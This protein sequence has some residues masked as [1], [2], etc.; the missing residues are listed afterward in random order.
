MSSPS[1]NTIKNSNKSIVIRCPASYRPERKYVFDIL[2]CDRFSI[3]YYLEDS[4]SDSTIIALPSGK[5]I[6]FPDVFF[7]RDENEPFSCSDLPTTVQ[8]IETSDDWKEE[9]FPVFYG[10]E[11]YVDSSDVVLQWD[12]IAVLFFCLARWEELLEYPRDA[13]DRFVGTDS[14]LVKQAIHMYPIVDYCELYLR[15]IFTRLGLDTE[16]GRT[17][18]SIS[19]HDVDIHRYY[20]APTSLLTV[21]LGD[22]VNR[23]NMTYA[24][25]T[26]WT[27]IKNVFTSSDPWDN[28]AYMR[29]Q[30]KNHGAESIFYYL[31]RKDKNAGASY[32]LTEDAVLREIRLL[33]EGQATIGAHPSLGTYRDAEAMANEVKVLRSVTGLP[34]VESRQHF[35]Q[36]HPI[37][38]V[39]ALEQ[40]GV[41]LDST[42]HFRRSPGFRSGTSVVYPL[43]NFRERRPSTVME[44]P[45]IFMDQN[46]HL[47][48]GSVEILLTEVEQLIA[49]TK[50]VDGSFVML[51]HNSSFNH[52]EWKECQKYF[53][54]ILKKAA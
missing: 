46:L 14:F 52:P 18:R 13:Y 17:Y 37:D 43:W 38:T 16:L 22:I 25:W 29:E 51:W 53:V 9:R 42:M 35:L 15:A 49:R 26:L 21:A 7:A 6:S 2:F 23:K 4:Q 32:H 19:T 34:I 33:A 50:A 40:A 31:P 36:W 30:D 39:D 44:R 27:G 48:S 20:R 1:L 45:L 5:S 54:D 41:E 10:V 47:H 28:N 24:W 11:D 12:V 3:D 8:W